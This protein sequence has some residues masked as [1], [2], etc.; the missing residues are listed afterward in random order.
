MIIPTDPFELAALMGR[1]LDGAQGY[2]SRY[3]SYYL[4]TQPGSFMSPESQEAMAGRCAQMSVNLIRLAVLSLA[5]R[6]RL[7][8]FAI[9]GA[10]DPDPDVMA[11][12][13]RCGMDIGS[14]TAMVDALIAGRSYVMGWADDV[15]D[16]LITAESARYVT[17]I[18]D[19]ATRRIVAALKRYTVVS[20]PDEP[21]GQ[22]VQILMT[23]DRVITMA[24]DENSPISAYPPVGSDAWRI[25]E[26]LPNPLGVP[27]IVQLTNGFGRRIG[28]TIEGESE[29][30]DLMPLVDAIN[31]LSQDLLV[32]SE[33]SARPRRWATGM[34]LVPQRDPETGEQVV[35]EDGEPQFESPFNPALDRV[36]Q[37][38]SVDARFGQ[39]EQASLA[40]Y[41]NAIQTLTGQVGAVSTLPA[42]YLG[43]FGDQP[44][45]A[46]SI[47][48][49][50]ASVTSRALGKIRMFS[51]TWE[52]VAA[53]EVGIRTG[54]DPRTVDARAMW[55]S[56][57]TRTPSQDADEAAKLG[58]LGVPLTEL[59]RTVLGWSDDQVKAV[60]EARVTEAVD[61]A[62]LAPPPPPAPAPAVTA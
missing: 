25:V 50:E 33:T 43:L 14:D 1:R 32:T 7:T 17:T 38:E 62:A 53:L 40:V 45:S 27:P 29:I 58:A 12:W 41:G 2:L 49:A 60:R 34:E 16:P 44:P 22:G 36:W 19:P 54:R 23:G 9:D 31:K 56:P 18:T 3:D 55:A 61:R 39:F 52:Q 8:G 21:L 15:G 37:S 51:P 10:N 11:S 42:H 30:S 46:D 28:T 57:E 26:S 24:T 4:G 35:D 13:R 20:D 59:L 5:E 48:A 6:L 47:R